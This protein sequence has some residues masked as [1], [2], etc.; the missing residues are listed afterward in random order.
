MILV[1]GG[2]GFIGANFVLDWLAAAGERAEAPQVAGVRELVEIDER[3]AVVREPVEHEVRTDEA[4]AAG[5]EDHFRR[6][7]LEGG[8]V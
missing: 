2:A 4:G 6:T 8:R 7:L 1:T 3:L 5:D